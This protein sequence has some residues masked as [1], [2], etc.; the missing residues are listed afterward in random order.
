MKSFLKV[1]LALVLILSL[2]S[3]ALAQEA[4]DISGLTPLLNAVADSARQYGLAAWRANKD[5]DDAAFTS[6]VLNALGLTHWQDAFSAQPASA[7]AP[8]DEMPPLK[9]GV[10][11]AQPIEARYLENGTVAV[12]AGLFKIP[13]ADAVLNEQSISQAEWM[14]TILFELTY[15][16]GA[17]YGYTLTAFMFDDTSAPAPRARDARAVF[18]TEDLKLYE[19]DTMGLSVRYPDFMQKTSETAHSVLF[20]A[21]EHPT[22]STL[23]IIVR[24]NAQGLTLENPDT[25]LIPS[26]AER[27][28]HEDMGYAAYLFEKDG[29]SFYVIRY[30]TQAKEYLAVISYLPAQTQAMQPYLAYI[31]NA[32]MIYELFNG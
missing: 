29:R 22:Q 25:S 6:A 32:L 24:D 21:P 1:C 10:Y 2:T 19:S 11:G 17:P 26:N 23:E 5:E 28:L 7:K 27:T 14:G 16:P 4:P 20:S 31:E 30:V 13:G 12:T 8:A 3:P 18:S 15:S 9:D